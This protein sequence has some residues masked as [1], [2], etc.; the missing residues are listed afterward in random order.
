MLKKFPKL[1]K[2]I[3]PKFQ[4]GRSTQDSIKMKKASL[5]AYIKAAEIS[6]MK[7]KVLKRT[8]DLK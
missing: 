1:V 8:Y 5:G 6:K 3:S 2:Y 4:E 7:R